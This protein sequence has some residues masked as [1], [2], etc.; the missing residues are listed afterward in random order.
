MHLH[1]TFTVDYC[2][3][4]CACVCVQLIFKHA[5]MDAVTTCLTKLTVSKAL[6]KPLNDP[7]GWFY[8]ITFYFLSS[9]LTVLYTIKIL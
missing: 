8:E 5:D 2:M 7:E 6:A 4:V 9:L 3:Y 1:V